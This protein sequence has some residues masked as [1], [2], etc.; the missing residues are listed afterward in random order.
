M[1]HNFAIE[2]Q[3][4]SEFYLA[5]NSVVCPLFFVN[6][7]LISNV[8]YVLCVNVYIISDG[9][10]LLECQIL[11]F[12]YSPREVTTYNARYWL[13]LLFFMAIHGNFVVVVVAQVAH[14]VFYMS[15]WR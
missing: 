13:L 8:K 15:N 12:L 14:I 1:W 4:F 3:R 9:H 7:K 6:T 11:K 5:L 10:F 2:A